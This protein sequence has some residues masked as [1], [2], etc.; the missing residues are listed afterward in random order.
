LTA[1]SLLITSNSLSTIESVSFPSPE[2]PATTIT[3]SGSVLI[4]KVVDKLKSEGAATA[5][6][7][8]HVK[9]QEP[10]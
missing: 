3:V 10:A 9:G 4:S 6:A 2:D 5:E 1:Q 7:E 8:F